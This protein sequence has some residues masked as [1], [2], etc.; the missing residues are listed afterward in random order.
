MAKDAMLSVLCSLGGTNSIYKT[1]E[2]CG[3]DVFSVD[4]MMVLSNMSVEAGAKNGIIE[5]NPKTEKYIRSRGIKKYRSVRSD[6][7]A[8]YEKTHILDLDNLEPQ[9]SKPHVP[10]NAKPISEIEIIDVDQ[11]FIGSCTGGRLEDLYIAAKVLKGRK[12]KADIRLIV[13]P[14]SQEVF[15][16]AVEKGIIEIL[17]QSGAIV[18]N[19]SCG[20]CVGIDK[21]LLADGEVCISSSSRNNRGRMGSNKAKIYLASPATVAASAIEGKIADPRKYL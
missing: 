10:T 19:S 12:V 1:L 15:R 4:G 8:I 13:T 20:A 2:Y 21:G 17:L 6:S 16:L 14:S 18:T 3:A 7:D 11:A 5:L 9:V